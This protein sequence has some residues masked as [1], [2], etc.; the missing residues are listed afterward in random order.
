MVQAKKLAGYSDTSSTAEIVKGIKEE[1]P[2]V[3]RWNFED[4]QF[5]KKSDEAKLAA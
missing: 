4:D 5:V 3:Y 2:I 1:N